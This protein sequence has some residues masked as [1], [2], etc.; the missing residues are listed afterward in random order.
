MGVGHVLATLMDAM[1]IFSIII[2]TSISMAT[3]PLPPLV[4]GKVKAKGGEIAGQL[5]TQ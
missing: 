3:L 4:R 5:R 1:D 2:S